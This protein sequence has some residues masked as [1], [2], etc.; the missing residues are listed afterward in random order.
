MRKLYPSRVW[1]SKEGMIPLR[2]IGLQSDCRGVIL[3][4]RGL[5]LDLNDE[6]VLKPSKERPGEHESKAGW[7][8]R[9]CY[10][11]P[12]VTMVE[13]PIRVARSA[14]WLMYRSPVRDCSARGACSSSGFPSPPSRITY[15]IPKWA[16]RDPTLSRNQ[17]TAPGLLTFNFTQKAPRHWLITG[18]WQ[19]QNTQYRNLDQIAGLQRKLRCPP[20][21]YQLPLWSWGETEPV[22]LCAINEGVVEVRGVHAQERGQGDGNVKKLDKCE[23][24]GQSL[25]HPSSPAIEVVVVLQQDDKTKR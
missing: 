5:W 24:P 21:S 12:A 23:V 10:R 18:T 4:N 8:A 19:T 3:T 1:C 6:R 2:P 7:D 16:C 15:S 14:S 20:M 9:Q 25:G 11:V 17:L 13:S 22:G